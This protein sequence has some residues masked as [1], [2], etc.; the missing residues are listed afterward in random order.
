MMYRD[1]IGKSATYSRT[2][3]ESDVY[4]FGGICGDLH[5]NHYDEQFMGNTVYKHRIAHGMLV[6]SYM[7]TAGSLLNQ[8][9]NWNTVSYGYDRVRFIKPVFIGDTLTATETVVKVDDDGKYFAE[10]TCTNQNGITVA[11][12]IHVS[13]FIEVKNKI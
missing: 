11:A 7:S 9:M 10:V 6:L 13:K 3:G 4:L 12:A 5:Q 1:C 2:V 8:K